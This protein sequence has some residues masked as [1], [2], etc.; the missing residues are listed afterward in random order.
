MSEGTPAALLSAALAAE[1]SRP[2]ITFYDALHGDA[3]RVELSVATFD[4]WVAKTANFL[5]DGL[6]AE[7]GE[8]V[9]LL[10]PLHWQTATWL[11][12]CWSAGLVACPI[13]EGPS[14]D[15][16]DESAA[17]GADVVAAGPGRLESALAARAPETVG[18]SLHP[19]G[20]PLAT[21]LPGVVDYAAEVRGYGDQFVPSAP[22]DPAAPA[23]LLGGQELSGAD[24]A[25][26]ARTAAT[27]WELAAA[28]RV[29]SA[30]PFDTID[31][32]L[33]SLLAPLAAGASVVLCGEGSTDASDAAGIRQ[34]LVRRV[35]TERVTAVA[36]IPASGLSCRSLE[37]PSNAE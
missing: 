8:R 11:L 24:L 18:V 1:P 35:E 36:G 33:V 31:G 13:G 29:L 30:V 7:P 25:E 17:R 37:I 10:L 22:V 27:R 19:L 26:R 9:A 4:N 21:P 23:L 12:A 6:A 28:D 20:A 15:G 32:V 2:L 34:D 14:A 3:G 16:T 5:V